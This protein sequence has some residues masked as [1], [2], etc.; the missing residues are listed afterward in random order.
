MKSKSFKRNRR[1]EFL[2]RNQRILLETHTFEIG[3]W[4]FDF[5]V[6]KLFSVSSFK[7][8]NKFLNNNKKLFLARS[9]FIAVLYYTLSITLRA[10]II[11]IIIIIIITFIHIMNLVF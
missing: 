4:V 11:I 10:I 2:K 3:L 7:L 6:L 9:K 1:N 8:K 5:N